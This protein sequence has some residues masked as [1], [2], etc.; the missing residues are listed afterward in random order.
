MPNDQQ[1]LDEE[2]PALTPEQIEDLKGA[3]SK[4]KAEQLIAQH[5]AVMPPGSKIMTAAEIIERQNT[6]RSELKFPD[7]QILSEAKRVLDPLLKVQCNAIVDISHKYTDV[8]SQGM[9]GPTYAIITKSG[10]E[11]HRLTFHEG[12]L[13]G[14]NAG[15]VNGVMIENLLAIV[16]D[17]LH[18]HQASKYACEEN[19]FALTNCENAVMWLKD[20]TAKRE[21][22]KVEGTHE[23]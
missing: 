14:E 12:P 19:G 8:V 4:I 9:E 11:V 10:R 17:R 23:V 7:G 1:W 22:R 2:S 20:R 13:A 15:D 21:E 18:M 3:S 16:I 5:G 6:P